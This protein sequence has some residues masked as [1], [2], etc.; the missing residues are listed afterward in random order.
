MSSEHE[1]RWQ[2][3]RNEIQRIFCYHPNPISKKS[4]KTF[5]QTIIDE[6]KNE[7]KEDAENYVISKCKD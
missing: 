4:Q 3:A 1:Q 7:L 6:V 5:V 2:N